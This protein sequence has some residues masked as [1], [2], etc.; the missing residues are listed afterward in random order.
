MAASAALSAS[1]AVTP[2]AIAAVYAA[3]GGQTI[4]PRV[5]VYPPKVPRRTR[6]SYVIRH[7]P[8]LAD[9]DH[10]REREMMR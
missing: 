5:L 8:L 4:N 7:A 6:L 3:A 10:D 1:S 2:L 9:V